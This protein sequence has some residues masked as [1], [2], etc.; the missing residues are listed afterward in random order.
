M[1]YILTHQEPHEAATIMAVSDDVES[2]KAYARDYG[3]QC[4]W[5][6][7][8]AKEWEYEHECEWWRQDL[9]YEAEPGKWKYDSSYLIREV[10][11]V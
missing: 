6:I 4:V 3:G 1:M 9:E 2:L 10:T 7:H 5:L 11:T 8:R